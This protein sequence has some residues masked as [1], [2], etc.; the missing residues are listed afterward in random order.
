[1]KNY[2]KVLTG[3]SIPGA[4]FEI[5]VYPSDEAIDEFLPIAGYW[6]AKGDSKDDDHGK[7]HKH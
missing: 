5:N 4:G 6:P 3:P 2:G 1:M 7:H